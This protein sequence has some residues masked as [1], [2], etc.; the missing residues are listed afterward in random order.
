MGKVV[1]PVSF[2][3]SKPEEA[4][5]LKH[6]NRRNFSGYV[7][8]LIAA[9][10]LHR[11]QEKGQE[12]PAEALEE[13]PKKT[14]AQKLQDLKSKGPI[15]TNKNIYKGSNDSANSNSSSKHHN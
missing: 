15:L 1:K 10:I 5:L 12:R 2:N 3:S 11:K 9:D 7:K 6:V 14:A 4:E 13:L 8:K